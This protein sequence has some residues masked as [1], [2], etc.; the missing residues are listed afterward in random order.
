MSD[1]RSRRVASSA[2]EKIGSLIEPTMQTPVAVVERALLKGNSGG[3]FIDLRSARA[4]S[5]PLCRRSGASADAVG[6]LHRKGGGKT[7]GC[8]RSPSAQCGPR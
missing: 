8:Q 2:G 4:P 6:H 3:R 5:V 7:D 1:V